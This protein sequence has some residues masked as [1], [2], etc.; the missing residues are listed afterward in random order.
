MKTNYVKQGLTVAVILLFLGVAFAPSI[1]A[2]VNKPDIDGSK[3]I[4]Y[5]DRIPKRNC[6]CEKDNPRDWNFPGICTVL[7][8]IFLIALILAINYPYPMYFIE[9]MMYIGSIFNCWWFHAIVP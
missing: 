2:D 3:L 5:L 8:P 9:I 4:D 7:F 1:N 6:D